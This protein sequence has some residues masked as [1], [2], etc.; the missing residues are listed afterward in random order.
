MKAKDVKSP[1]INVCELDDNNVCIGCNRSI[2]EIIAN[3]SSE[4]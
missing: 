2:E 4:K 3:C 1:C